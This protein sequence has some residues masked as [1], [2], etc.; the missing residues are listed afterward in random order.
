MRCHYRLLAIALMLSAAALIPTTAAQTL[1]RQL[2]A[3]DGG[4]FDNF[5]DAL[6]VE[7]AVMVVG[8]PGHDVAGNQQ[9]GAA[10]VFVS[11]PEGWS[12]APREAEQVVKLIASDGQRDDS[13]GNAVAIDGQVIA[14]A[15]AR[16]P[17]DTFNRVGGVYLYVEPP[18][19][20]QSAGQPAIAESALLIASDGAFAD[21]MG[22]Q[23]GMGNNMVVASAPG[24]GNEEGAIFVFERPVGGWQ[25]IVN[26]SARLEGMFV[27]PNFRTGQSLGFDGQT[28]VAGTGPF[29]ANRSFSIAYVFERPPG[30]WSGVVNETARLNS[31][32]TYPSFSRDAIAVD[33]GLVAVGVPEFQDSADGRT[34]A[35]MLFERTP[36]GW[37]ETVSPSATLRESQGIE[38]GQFGGSIAIDGNRVLVGR[39][40]S[41]LA[42]DNNVGSVYLFQ[43]P[44]SGWSGT[45]NEDST[46]LA[47]NGM[48]DDDF[49]RAIATDGITLAVGA[50]RV[51]RNPLATTVG[52]VFHT[53]LQ[54]LDPPL[55]ADGFEVP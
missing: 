28:V 36:A 45:L 3:S 52:S 50:P 32:V 22:F 6:A 16:R 9:Q 27:Q 13:L 2:F 40:F 47:T 30:G 31:I 10:F 55:F 44:S 34:G 29:T 37:A 42:E 33:D 8:A 43:Q 15:A 21:L 5:G 20:W 19:G 35:V 12:G 41:T 53:N 46:L 4:S 25:G 7:G 39:S 18:G 26:E 1:D 14:V 48:A 49:G 11:P 51:D 24:V 54:Q 38:N 23:I 17:S